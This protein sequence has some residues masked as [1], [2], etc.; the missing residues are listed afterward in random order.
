[1]H[2]IGVAGGRDVNGGADGDESDDE[3]VDWGSGSLGAEDFAFGEGAGR[4]GWGERSRVFVGQGAVGGIWSVVVREFG[5]VGRG[6]EVGD[7]DGEF[8]TE[9]EG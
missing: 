3:E 2:E 5:G 7:C 6:E 4:G 9:E 1:M 8:G